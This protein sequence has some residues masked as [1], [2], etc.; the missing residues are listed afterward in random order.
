MKIKKLTAL[1][2][3]LALLFSLA[4][5]GAP[6]AEAPAATDAP[7]KATEAPAEPTAAPAAAAE[8]AAEAVTVRLA[9]LTGPTAMGMAKIFSDADAGTAANDYEYALYGAADELTCQANLQVWQDW[10][11]LPRM[12]AV[13]A[14]S[15]IRFSELSSYPGLLTGPSSEAARL[16]ALLCGHEDFSTVAF[17]TEGGLFDE[18][19]IATV[20]CGPGSMDQGHKPDEFVSVEQLAACDAML[21]RLVEWLQQGE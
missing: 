6:A 20:I 1:A 13:S 11:L 12:R 4:A 10:A 21:G 7:V 3:A 15:D 19:G 2:L 14:T 8:E 17:G 18:A 16:L 9:A 5:C